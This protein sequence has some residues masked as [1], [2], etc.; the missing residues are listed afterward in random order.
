MPPMV[1]A[2]VATTTVSS[3]TSPVDTALAA[4]LAP[5]VVKPENPKS[6]AAIEASDMASENVISTVSVVTVCEETMTGA[7]LSVAATAAWS[8]SSTGVPS[9]SVM[10]PTTAEYDTKG[11]A[12]PPRTLSVKVRKMSVSSAA[13]PLVVEAKASVPAPSTENPA[14][15]A[16]MLV[17]LMVSLNTTRNASRKPSPSRSKV[18]RP[19]IAGAAVWMV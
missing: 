15:A 11:V 3:A 7:T 2:R 9:L 14:P 12:S 1:A 8:G 10:L 6:A 16:V 17:S 5:P 13:S 19:T 18:S 4:A